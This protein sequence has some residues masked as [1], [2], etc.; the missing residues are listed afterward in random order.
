[1][2]FI[3]S[4]YIAKRLLQN[5]RHVCKALDIAHCLPLS[6]YFLIVGREITNSDNPTLLLNEFNTYR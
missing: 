6:N 1:M 5:Y 2:F 3:P 4:V